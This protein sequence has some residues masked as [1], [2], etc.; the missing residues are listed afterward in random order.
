MFD[1]PAL[2]VLPNQLT[3][4]VDMPWLGIERINVFVMIATA[5]QKIRPIFDA[6]FFDRFETIGGKTRTENLYRLAALPRQR[7]Q[8]LVGIRFK[9]FLPAETRLKRCHVFV[10]SQF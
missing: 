3:Q 10:R 1:F 6:N 7:F 9:P 2:K 8:R 5:A 4:R